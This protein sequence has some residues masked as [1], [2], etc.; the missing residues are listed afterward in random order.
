[1]LVLNVGRG[2]CDEALQNHAAVSSHIAREASL[3]GASPYIRVRSDLMWDAIGGSRSYRDF[4]VLCAVYAA[5]GAKAYPVRIIRPRIIAGAL[6]YKAPALMTPGSLAERA[7]NATPLTTDQ[8]RYTLDRLEADG[9]FA[10][11]QASPRCTYF[12]HRMTRAELA[13]NV[14]TMKTRR[15]VRLRD[16]RAAD[17]VLQ[18][19]IRDAIKVGKTANQSPRSPRNVPA[20]PTSSPHTVPTLIQTGLT[21]ASGIEPKFI[22]PTV[23]TSCHAEQGVCTSTLSPM[24]TAQHADARTVS[25]VFEVFESMI[26]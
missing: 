23:H 1:M 6:G 16:N 24:V 19:K 11:V 9:L 17:R 3:H 8:L 10:R 13:G 7:D 4:S 22:S 12:S 5:I 2:N 26:S 15:A 21:E 18:E 25:E 14:L 20:T